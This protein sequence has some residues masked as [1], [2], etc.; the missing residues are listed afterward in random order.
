MSGV[1]VGVGLSSK[2]TGD[3]VRQLV[4]QVVAAGGFDLDAV[5]SV[6]TRERLVD[7]ER[8]RLGPPVVGVADDTLLARYPA[9]ERA[10]GHR[11]FAAR[12]AEG[13]ALTTAGERSRLLIGTTRSAHAPAALAVGTDR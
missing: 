2:A 1:V 13:C 7:D 8:L 3:E 5:V 12:V 10:D 6:A 11:R 9:P 4:E